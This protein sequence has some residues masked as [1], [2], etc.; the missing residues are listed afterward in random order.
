MIE[1]ASR[2]AAHDVSIRPQQYLRRLQVDLNS[3]PNLVIPG[4]DS[5]VC[6]PNFLRQLQPMT[7]SSDTDMVC[8]AVP[9][10]V[11]GLHR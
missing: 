9:C 4:S 6:L 8:C 7:I 10:C 1:E 2:G 3:K 11:Q 5:L